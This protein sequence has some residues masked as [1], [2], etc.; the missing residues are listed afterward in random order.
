MEGTYWY[1][2]WPFGPFYGHLVHF[3]V[4]WSILWSNGI[5]FG[6]LV[7]FMAKWYILWPFGEFNGHLGSI[8]PPVLVCCTM[9]NLATMHGDHFS[10]KRRNRF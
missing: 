9:K 4:I 6:H 10:L 2:L 1:I 5:F 7:H 8:F 3:M